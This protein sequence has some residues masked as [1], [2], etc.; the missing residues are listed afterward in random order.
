M[1][2]AANEAKEGRDY[3]Q[4]RDRAATTGTIAHALIEA[5]LNGTD[6]DISAYPAD[7]LDLAKPSFDAFMAWYGNHQIEVI[8]QECKHVSKV[9]RFGGCFD[10]LI[11]LDG[12]MTLADWK[13]S[14]DIYGSMVAQVGAYYHLI[15]ENYPRSR[16]PRQA[17]IV[18]AGKDGEMR[19]VTLGIS[20]LIFGWN[21]FQAALVVFN[22]RERLDTLVRKPPTAL[23]PPSGKVTLQR[24]A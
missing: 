8:A 15:K 13:S 18:R 16:W 3:R 12:V 5:F 20:D 22:A 1:S 17:V 19:T 2:W 21:V 4:T 11:T 9:A 24:I 7:L 6:V 23:K 10:A 14:K